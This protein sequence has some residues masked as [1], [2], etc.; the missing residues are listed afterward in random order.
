MPKTH[1]QNCIKNM[2]VIVSK[3]DFET[4]CNYRAGLNWHFGV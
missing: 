1:N 3:A 2:L 4:E